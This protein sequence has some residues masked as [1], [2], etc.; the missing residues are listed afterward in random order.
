MQRVLF[1]V[2][3]ALGVLLLFLAGISGTA[4]TLKTVYTFETTGPYG[5]YAN[6]VQ[7][8]DGN[9]Y[10]TT[11]D[12]GAHGQGTVYRLT[13]EGKLTT[14]Y[15][16]CSLLNC[17]DG[18]SPNAP[19]VLGTDGNFYGTTLGGGTGTVYCGEGCGTI[20]KLS[21]K[22]VFTVL[23]NFCV[24]YP[25][26]DGSQPDS[27]LVEGTDGNFYGVTPYYG[28]ENL[29]GTV[30]KVSPSGIF[31]TLYAF[32]QQ[33]DCTDGQMPRASLIQGTNGELYGTTEE[34]GANG[35]G[36]VF[37]I[38]PSGGTPAIVH[39]FDQTDGEAPFSRLFQ[40]SN[41][42]FYGMAQAGGTY[43]C[44]LGYLCGTLYEM[45]PSS[46][47]FTWQFDFNSTNGSDPMGGFVQA[48]D[49]NL[50]GATDGGGTYDGGTIF[51]VTPSGTLAT[52]YD[53]CANPC[54]DGNSPVFGIFQSTN[55]LFYGI[56]GSQ[57][58]G[59]YYEIVFS[60]AV[61]GLKP[62]ITALPTSGKVG[63]VVKILGNN[64][65]GTTAVSFDGTNQP[66][67]TVVS[68]TEIT[69]T[70]PS[71]ATSGK[72]VVTTPAGQ[73]STVVSFRVP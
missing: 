7:G 2:G 66:A 52:L 69:T 1:G 32:C 64:L 48:G 50:Y 46:G 38:S 25:C 21:P 68:A 3:E 49:G 16:F 58:E 59:N 4:Q 56:A 31:T 20:F 18:A 27:G 61:P 40:A 12:G 29:Q 26:D 22:G 13:P 63:S 71:G 33:N 53:F 10:G 35:Y 34:G 9:L 28:G 37:E 8:L 62:F 60:F 67:F 30:Y 14:I 44:A 42:S 73:L 17:A 43:A 6:V 41:G 15:S 65:T 24:E 57:T 19:V 23:H 36:E 39:S 11:A 72:I 51:K 45:N 55:G 5:P 54:I 70:V 47:A